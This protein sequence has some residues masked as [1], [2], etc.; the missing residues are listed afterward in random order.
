MLW[1]KNP[2]KIA[3]WR[4]NGS[5]TICQI[6]T[7]LHLNPNINI[8]IS[9]KVNLVYPRRL[10]TTSL[11]CTLLK[12]W[13]TRVSSRY[14]NTDGAGRPEHS[15]QYTG[16]LN[17]GVYS[18][19]VYRTQEYTVYWYTEHSIQYTGILNTGVYSILV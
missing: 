13:S 5:N 15:I 1:L 17:T 14:Q 9:V 8:C 3:F 4:R 12:V 7:L 11:P 16:I 10:V 2:L 19:L 6:K 18:I